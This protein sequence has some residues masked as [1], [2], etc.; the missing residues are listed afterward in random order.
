M[1]MWL[2]QMSQMLWSPE[3]HRLDSGSASAGLQGAKVIG[4][5][6]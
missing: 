3:R 1:S 2:Y 6:Q 4:S 5:N